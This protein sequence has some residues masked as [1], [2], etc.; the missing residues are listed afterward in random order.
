MSGN[1]VRFALSGSDFSKLL[2]F[3]IYRFIHLWSA[4]KSLA[5][6]IPANQSILPVSIRR[7]A[8]A[9]IFCRSVARFLIGQIF[10]LFATGGYK[11]VYSFQF[12]CCVSTQQHRATEEIRLLPI[13]IS[14]DR[15]TKLAVVL[16]RESRDDLHGKHVFENYCWIFKGWA[17]WPQHSTFFQRK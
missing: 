14:T 3:I 17:F 13:H 12:F 8:S 6:M 7:K 15:R 16:Q 5:G 2:L 10:E 9:G 4:A 11:W 1:A